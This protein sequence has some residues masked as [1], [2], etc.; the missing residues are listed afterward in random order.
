MNVITTAHLQVTEREN[1][2]TKGEASILGGFRDKIDSYYDD[3]LYTQ[4]LGT[5]YFIHTQGVNHEG[6]HFDGNVRSKGLPKSLEDPTW[7]G[8]YK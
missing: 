5:K 3:I 1:K 7:G 6:V 2:P 4:K 8:L